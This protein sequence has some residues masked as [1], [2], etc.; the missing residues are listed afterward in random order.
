MKFKPCRLTV[1]WLRYEIDREGQ[2]RCIDDFGN[3]VDSMIDGCI[4]GCPLMEEQAAPIR[5]EAAR[6]RLNKHRRERDQV[7]RDMGMV[8]VRGALG[9]TYWE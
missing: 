9:G 7:M 2:V 8:K 1:N 6:R 3:Y 4:A 5:A